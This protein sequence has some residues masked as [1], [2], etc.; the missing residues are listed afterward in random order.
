MPN[1]Y[2]NNGSGCQGRGKQTVRTLRACHTSEAMHSMWVGI[3]RCC[4]Y[5]QLLKWK[6][7]VEYGL[8][9]LRAVC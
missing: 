1:S 7:F 6:F 3:S 4:V 8:L 2:E 9:Y 5:I